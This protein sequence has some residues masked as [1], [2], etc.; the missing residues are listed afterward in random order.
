MQT[1]F[2]LVLQNHSKSPNSCRC[3]S[4]FCYLCGV[5]WKQ[6]TCPLWDESRLTERA[7]ALQN[8]QDRDRPAQPP[9]ALQEIMQ[10]LEDDDECDHLDWCRVNGPNTCDIC[11]DDLEYWIWICDECRRQACTRCRFNRT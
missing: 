6:C 7:Q 9:R 11:D 3:G 5:R 4:E 10:H 8:R 1:S 2:L